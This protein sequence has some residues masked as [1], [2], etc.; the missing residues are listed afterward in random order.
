MVLYL[1]L[2]PRFGG[3]GAAWATAGGFA[4]R[5]LLTYKA[6]QEVW[7]I[8]Y[9]WTK[10]Q[11]LGSGAVA[12]AGVSMLSLQNSFIQQVTVGSITFALYLG[13]VLF[14]IIS[15]EDRDRL[16]ALLTRKLEFP[17]PS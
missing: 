14:F 11:L 7:P 8:A 17:R 9:R 16:K 12:A 15:D 5:C 10:V 1:S 4:V 6:A 3:T 2:I 13:A